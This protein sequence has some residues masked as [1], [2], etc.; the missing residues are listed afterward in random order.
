MS[1]LTGLFVGV[2]I[3][4]TVGLVVACLLFAARERVDDEDPSRGTQ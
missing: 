3:G 2:L 4:A 1:F